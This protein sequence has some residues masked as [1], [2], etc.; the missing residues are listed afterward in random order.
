M[1]PRNNLHK[2]FS[3]PVF[4]DDDKKTRLANYISIIVPASLT[5]LAVL[6]LVR[7]RQGVSPLDF[8]NLILFAVAGVLLFVWI[9]TKLGSVQQAC[10]L[11]IAAIWTAST[12][13][14]LTGS[15]IRGVGYASY[16]VVMLLAG[17]LLGSRAAAIIAGF[18]IVSGF[19]LAYAETSGMIPVSLDPPL[20]VAIE[21]AFIFMI[22]TVIIRLTISSLQVALDAA[23]RNAEEVAAR[24]QELARFREELEVHIQERTA[25]LEKRA[26][27]LQT[28]SI[29]ARD[30]AS[31][32]DLDSLLPKTAG[33][34]SEQF[35]FYHAGIF[36]IDDTVEYAVLKAA[37]SEGGRQMLNRG[38]RLPLDDKSIVGFVASR[39]DP[40]IALDVGADSVYFNNPDL[41][42]TRSEMALPLQ[43]NGKVIGVLDVQSKEVNAFV[44]EDIF[45]LSTLAAQIAVAFE[46]AQLYEETQRALAESRSTFETYIKQEWSSFV[47]Q[48]RHA[49]FIFD[50]KHMIPIDKRKKFDHI[51]PAISLEKPL[52]SGPSSTITLPIKLRGQTIGVLDVRSKSGEREW[53]KDEITLL[54]AAAERAGLALENARLVETAQ[55]RASRERSIVEISA[56]I[57]AVSDI[58]SILQTTVEELGRKL[59]SATEVTFELNPEMD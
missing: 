12:I 30:I 52:S 37:N 59:R 54:E 16:F 15:G 6:I 35:G 56:K 19:A 22:S 48:V 49:G 46:N 42:E 53:T 25:S 47:Q 8:S 38:H 5:A 26:L 50:G 33:L 18:S 11:A 36:L 39:G 27:Q 2:I 40:R 13:L 32:K 29:L 44:Q 31:M 24:N 4:P 41:P 45:V 1:T 23:N 10:Y 55:R 21:I 14:A 34:V 28:V 17:L 9:L 3:P 58:D 51:Q 43:A 7:I 57:G 20:V